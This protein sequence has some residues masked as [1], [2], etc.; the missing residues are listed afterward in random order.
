MAHLAEYAAV[1]ARDALNCHAAAVRVEAHV[2]RC[3]AVQVHI[4]RGNLPVFNQAGNRRVIREETA[5]TMAD[6]HGVDVSDLRALQPGAAVAR[7]PGPHH[8]ALVAADDVEG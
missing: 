4:L 5:F 2:H 3:V 6:R 8:A 1:G 7:D